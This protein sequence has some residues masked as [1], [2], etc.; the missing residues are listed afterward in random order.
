MIKHHQIA[1]RRLLH[2]AGAGAAVLAA[3][4]LLP[5]PAAQANSFKEGERAYL[6]QDFKTSLRILSG[7]AQSGHARAQYLLGRQYQFG[8]GVARS[9]VQAYYWYSRAEK[10]GHVEAGLF[11][12]L[13]VAKWR[14]SK[15]EVAEANKLLK[16]G[17]QA[18]ASAK[19]PAPAA[20]PDKKTA[21]KPDE[22]TARAAR[23]AAKKVHGSKPTP[24]ETANAKPKPAKKVAKKIVA[25]PKRRVAA[26]PSLRKPKPKQVVRRSVAART[27][28]RA[29]ARVAPRSRV[30]PNAN[31]GTGWVRGAP[32]PDAQAPVYR[33]E[34]ALPPQHYQTVPQ[35]DPW[36][37]PRY[38]RRRFANGVPAYVWQLPPWQRR[39]WLA[40]HRWRMVHSRFYRR[41][42]RAYRRF[43]NGR[44][45]RRW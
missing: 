39:R 34:P 37:G 38:P 15:A 25:P 4:L 29:P 10:N 31:A 30:T 28:V 24:A 40:R 9:N 2:R 42:W 26:R 13:L 16:G 21:A 22:K 41:A 44:R 36:A 8:Q 1:V 45:Y 33:D 5:A 18:L 11:R 7:L 6:Q 12:H 27:P 35:H 43:Q 19:Q 17:N 32:A 20:T 14:M 3:A 23:E